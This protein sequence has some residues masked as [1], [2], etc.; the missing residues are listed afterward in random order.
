[1][2]V[3]RAGRGRFHPEQGGGDPLSQAGVRLGHDVLHLD[4]LVPVTPGEVHPVNQFLPRRHDIRDDFL[5]AHPDHHVPYPVGHL[6]QSRQAPHRELGRHDRRELAIAPADRHVLH[7]VQRVHQIVPVGRNLHRDRPPVFAGAGFIAV[8]QQRLPNPFCAERHAEGILNRLDRDGSGFLEV[9]R[10]PDGLPEFGRVGIGHLD[11][12]DRGPTIRQ[13]DRQDIE[14]QQHH[15]EVRARDLH[16]QLTV[17]HTD[18]P[19]LPAV[20]D[21]GERQDLSFLVHQQREAVM[22][23]EDRPVLQPLRVHGENFARGHFLL[24][25]QGREADLLRFHERVRHR[26]HDLREPVEPD[27]D[28]AAL[29][30][31]NV[32]QFL[33]GLDELR[34][35]FA[36]H[37]VADRGARGDVG[38]HALKALH[39]LNSAFRTRRGFEERVGGGGPLQLDPDLARDPLAGPEVRA[40]AV[41]QFEPDLATLAV[42]VLQ[43]CLD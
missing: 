40:V 1:M 25:P 12:L 15:R 34:Q 29:S 35:P 5:K 38:P 24:D 9:E 14:R 32:G 10:C 18:F 31:E 11:R 30:P 19:D 2:G 16:E 22:A 20:D 4:D 17:P 28:G 33:L 13:V 3:E 37:L 36:G 27:R 23:G 8:G 41:M 7:H 26:K 43:L 6:F 39:N 42:L 21:R